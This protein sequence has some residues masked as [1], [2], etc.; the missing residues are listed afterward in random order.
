MRD[1]VRLRRAFVLKELQRYR[2][3]KSGL[4]LEAL[5]AREGWVELRNRGDAPVSLG[6]MV[7]TTN[8]RRSIPE[9]LVPEHGAPAGTRLPE[10]I[11]A[12]GERVRFSATELGLSFTPDGELGV[13]DGQSVAG[14]K[15]VLFYG[16]LPDGKHYERAGDGTWQVR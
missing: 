13:F 9:L 11:L 10:R 14:M 5:D 4:V 6:G 12:P 16:K 2:T 7:L 3:R 15:D 1:F 8:L